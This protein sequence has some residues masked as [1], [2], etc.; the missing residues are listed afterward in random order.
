MEAFNVLSNANNNSEHAWSSE[1]Q[2][3]KY[4]W[5]SNFNLVC[6]FEFGNPGQP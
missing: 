1:F 6:L 4:F 3:G 5:A 2:I